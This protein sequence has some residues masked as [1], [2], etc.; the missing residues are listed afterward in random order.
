VVLLLSIFA[1]FWDSNDEIRAEY[2]IANGCVA[3]W[4]LI[5]IM[6]ETHKH[7]WK[8]GTL[9]GVVWTA[10]VMCNYQALGTVFPLISAA[11]AIS[12]RAVMLR[13]KHIMK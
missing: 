4:N 13:V 11:V 3:G 7:P 8:F 12:G 6:Y 1:F 9:W 2:F 5:L 10:F